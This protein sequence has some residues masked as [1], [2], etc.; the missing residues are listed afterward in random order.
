M[1]SA[2][3]NKLSKAG[4]PSYLREGALG[5][6]TSRKVVSNVMLMVAFAYSPS[7]NRDSRK[8]RKR[9][10][11]HQQAGFAAGTVTNDD[12]LP[13]DFSHGCVGMSE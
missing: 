2:V 3:A 1:L 12:K 5:K 6:N 8:D 9:N 11:L 7:T 4:Q 10:N 13:A